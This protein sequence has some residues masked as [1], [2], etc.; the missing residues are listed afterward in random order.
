MH[1]GKH[2][3]SAFIL[4]VHKVHV[5][6]RYKYTV[7]VAARYGRLQILRLRPC[8]APDACFGVGP[9]VRSSLSGPQCSQRTSRFPGEACNSGLRCWQAGIGGAI[10]GPGPGPGRA[11]RIT[12]R[13]IRTSVGSLEGRRRPAAAA[14]AGSRATTTT[15]PGRGRLLVP[16][17]APSRSREPSAGVLRQA[18]GG[19]RGPSRRAGRVPPCRRPG[20]LPGRRKPATPR[21]GKRG[22]TV[23]GAARRAQDS[24][25]PPLLYGGSCV[26]TQL[27]EGPSGRRRRTPRRALTG[28]RRRCLRQAAATAASGDPTR[29]PEGGIGAGAAPPPPRSP[30]PPK[31]L[32]PSIPACCRPGPAAWVGGAGP[33]RGG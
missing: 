3:S 7:R 33:A 14:G 15:R 19:C 24:R 10:R 1:R 12:T 31:P 6:S 13:R 29:L 11:I 17:R 9:S 32:S 8:L 23:G 30:P 28:P 2:S 20:N 21:A 25:P 16:P 26:P 5:L 18:E 4:M 22:H 27:P